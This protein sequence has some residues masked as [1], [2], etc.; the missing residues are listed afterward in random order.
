MKRDPTTD[1]PNVWFFAREFLHAYIPTIRGLSVNTVTAYRISLECFLSFLTQTQ[2]VNHSEVT[3]NHFSRSVLKEWMTWMVTVHKYA[4]RTVT[5]RLSAIKTF[6]SYSSHEDITL[7]ALSQ[8]AQTLKGQNAPKT[9]IEYLFEHETKAILAA[10]TGQSL[11]SRRNRMLLILLYETAARVGE[12]TALR[13]Q[14][15]SLAPGRITLTGKGNKMRVVPL[16][17]KT[18]EHLQIYLTEFHPN[19]TRNTGLRPL[20]YSSHHGELCALSV[21]TVALV[22][23]KAAV[24]AKESCPTVPERIHCHML[25]KTKAMALY[26]Q[27]IPLPVIMRLLGHESV[28]TTAAFYA[29]ATQEMMREAINAAMPVLDEPVTERLTQERLETLYSLR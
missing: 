28:S 8:A 21:D 9:P 10:F 12:I 15:L 22:L 5:L 25:R 20:F 29:F 26:Q 16:T 7:I 18:V 1:A 4:P 24:L 3:F 6:L 14:D 23:K 27:K 19:S 13:L 11:K 17:D 2:N